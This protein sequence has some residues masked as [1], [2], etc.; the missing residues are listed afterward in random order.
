MADDSFV[1]PGVSPSA[2]VVRTQADQDLI[3]SH[4]SMIAVNGTPIPPTTYPEAAVGDT[5][6]LRASLR[7]TQ[8]SSL[9]DLQFGADWGAGLRYAG[10]LKGRYAECRYDESA[11]KIVVKVADIAP[12]GNAP[13]SCWYD[14]DLQVT[15]C[16]DLYVTLYTDELYACQTV[17]RYGVGLQLRTPEVQYTVS[18]SPLNLLE[19]VRQPVTVTIENIGV[20]TAT[21]FLLDTDLETFPVT[22][23]RVTS[24]FS[25]DPQTGV[26]AAEAPIESGMSTRLAFDVR[27]NNNSG[28]RTPAGPLLFQPSYANDCGTVFHSPLRYVPFD[29]PLQSELQLYFNYPDD[30]VLRSGDRISY[31]LVLTVPDP[32]LFTGYITVT[33]DVPAAIAE[34]WPYI[35][36]SV[37]NVAVSGHTSITWSVLPREAHNARLTITGQL[38]EAGLGG[39]PLVNLAVAQA[40]D[41]R[42]R[43]LT[44]N[45]SRTNDAVT[46]AAGNALA[47]PPVSQAREARNIMAAVDAGRLI[48]TNTYKIR[49][50]K[51]W[52]WL[53][54]LFWDELH[55]GGFQYVSGTAEYRL[56]KIGAT[57]DSFQDWAP[58]PEKNIRTEADGSLII[59]LRFLNNPATGETGRLE[60]A[61][62][63]QTLQLRYTVDPPTAAANENRPRQ[64]MTTLT[65]PNSP[66]TRRNRWQQLL[67]VQMA[68]SGPATPPPLYL[69]LDL[70]KT[71]EEHETYRVNLNVKKILPDVF[72]DLQ[73]TLN[74]AGYKNDG[75]LLFSGFNNI[76]PRVKTTDAGRISFGFDTQVTQG[77]T[78]TIPLKKQCRTSGK[79]TASATYRSAADN[80]GPG[81]DQTVSATCRPIVNGEA[82]LDL[83]VTPTSC[84]L[85]SPEEPV[86]WSLYVTNRGTG[87]A[88]N[89]RLYN[90][91]GP[92][93]VFE[94]AQVQNGSV[95]PEVSPNYPSFGKTELLWRLGDIEPSHTR[96]V[97]VTAYPK[98]ATSGSHILINP[99]TVYVATGNDDDD[100]A[101]QYEY[102]EAP[103][104]RVPDECVSGDI[105]EERGRL[106]G[107]FSATQVY[108]DNLYHTA[109]NEEDAWVT[110]LTPGIWFAAPASRKRMVEIVTSSA[111]PGGLAVQPF[112]EKADRTYQSYLLYS[113]QFE[114]YDEHSDHNMT[115]HRVDSYFRYN[116]RNKFSL[117]LVDQFKRSHDSISSRYFTI[118][119]KYKSNVFNAVSTFD[120][121]EKTRLRADY[122]NFYLNYDADRNDGAD[123]MDNGGSVYGFFRMTAKTSLF[124][125][126]E[127]ADIDYDSNDLDSREMRYF[128]GIRWEITEKSSGR[129]KGGYGKKT[130]DEDAFGEVDTWMAEI[131]VDHQLTPKTRLVFNAYRRYDE[132]MGQP[133][134][135]NNLPATYSTHI[136]TQLAGLSVSYDVTPKL[137]FNCHSTFFTDTYDSYSSVV[138]AAAPKSR[139]D[140]EF[141]FSPALKFDFKKWLTF[142]LSYIYTNRDSNYS[143]YDYTDNTT[144]LRAS[145][146]H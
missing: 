35:K 108:I 139:K 97:A 116:T 10:N 14:F 88:R 1:E 58:V 99:N 21:D 95:T 93:L 61:S 52:N 110:Y 64:T 50:E 24:G 29:L 71:I 5:I 63:D 112:Y 39:R 101:C 100:G 122:N 54:A 113:P 146:Y 51:D 125:E 82:E 145:V 23:S 75:E 38:S 107:F 135:V 127:F 123:R 15:D 36:S 141:A 106:H 131:V 114:F 62:S 143:R 66:D 74:A 13:A 30:T 79:I 3:E 31:E 78:V 126:Y 92:N 41:R 60:Q 84:R 104:F 140:T 83:T 69:S 18:P 11:G 119:D 6:T 65:L 57:E 72:D 90:V 42:G 33:H 20:G 102:V 103:S 25:Y 32:E 98:E 133:L 17:K 40:A 81:N 73:V 134:D 22:V 144:L 26:F 37:G 53:G 80:G 8:K 111:A 47:G 118:D 7:N 124:A 12:S 85:V 91:L 4:L 28:G 76:E 44:V 16:R 109:A 48:L 45:A 68:L 130:Y 70:P 117:R 128:G 96:Q 49:P 105:F 27:L 77:G 9:Y 55:R 2:A 87:K 132:N 56:A 67:P 138:G 137:H 34:Q 115:T 120:I 19:G 94:S 59:E 46:T 89:V 121:T 129:I 86:V 136:L 43:M 142:D